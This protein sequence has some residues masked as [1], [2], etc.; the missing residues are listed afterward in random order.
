MGLKGSIAQRLGR[1]FCIAKRVGLCKIHLKNGKIATH[2][3][4]RTQSFMTEERD[5]RLQRLHA[6]R[7]RGVNPYP[8]R[9]TR[10]HTIA[11]A[12]HHFEEDY[13]NTGGSV[14]L[15]GLDRHH[16]LSDHPLATRKPLIGVLP[17]V[18]ELDERARE[19]SM[20]ADSAGFNF[21]PQRVKTGLKYRNFPIQ[22]GSTLRYEE[23]LMEKYSEDAK[24]EVSDI[25]VTEI[26]FASKDDTHITVIH[27]SD[28][29]LLIPEFALEPE[30]LHTKLSEVSGG[31]DIDFTEHPEFSKR[32]YLR[33]DD[34]QIVR[35]FFS[36]PVIQFLESH[37]EMHI[38]CHKHR[39][40]IFKKRDL[41]TPEEIE[42]AVKFSEGF[43]AVAAKRLG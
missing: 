16:A 32:Y 37:D 38:E 41:M 18:V 3:W 26:L 12:L 9:V 36:G 7:E 8:N 13:H 14:A 42:G 2:F 34:E 5:V 33:G 30:S 35:N 43:L 6:L 22:K 15:S 21:F 31:R 39:L 40:L 25:T 29:D 27:L 10:S 24:I 28:T 19:L 17:A 20:F 11:E 4:R 1:F 23:N